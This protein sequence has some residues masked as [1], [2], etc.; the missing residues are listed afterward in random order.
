MFYSRSIDRIKQYL[1][2]Y[3]RRKLF[4]NPVSTGVHVPQ[5]MLEPSNEV[6]KQTQLPTRPI[7]K[8]PFPRTILHTS[9]LKIHKTT[10]KS[11]RDILISKQP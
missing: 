3:C 5:Y 7:Q 10:P 6:S 9:N 1:L 8:I 4:Y 11:Y 2:N